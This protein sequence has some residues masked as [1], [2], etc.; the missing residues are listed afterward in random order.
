MEVIVGKVFFDHI[1]FIAQANDEFMESIGRIDFH[2]MPEDGAAANFNHWF[3]SQ[4]GFFADAGTEST[5]QND[6]FHRTAPFLL[7]IHKI[8]DEAG[9][10][11]YL[12]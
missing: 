5:R 10:S 2:D 9:F 8:R 4:I 1:A 7:Y 11:C 3:R 6:N 12:S